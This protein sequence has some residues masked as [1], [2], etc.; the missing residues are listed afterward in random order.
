MR[1]I[2]EETT[3]FAKL[4]TCSEQIQRKSSNK[5]KP[6]LRRKSELPHDS[7]TLKALENHKHPDPFLTAAKES[8]SG[9]P[10]PRPAALM[11]LHSREIYHVIILNC[12]ALCDTLDAK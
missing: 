9:W 11:M 12:R 7:Y 4:F 3:Y 2:I 10:T 8:G 5:D 1:L 6:L